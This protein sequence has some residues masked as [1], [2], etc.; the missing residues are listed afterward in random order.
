MWLRKA[1]LPLQGQ[2]ERDRPGIFGRATV[3]FVLRWLGSLVPIV[4]LSAVRFGD[5]VL[6]GRGGDRL[7]IS[8]LFLY[9]PIFVG[10]LEAAPDSRLE[11]IFLPG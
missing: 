2:Y 10:I 4:V 3:A 7:G 1:Y 11:E 5:D 8:V 9:Q 6:C